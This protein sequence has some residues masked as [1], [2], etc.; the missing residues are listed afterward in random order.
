[1]SDDRRNNLVIRIGLIIT[2]HR[3]DTAR[4]GMRWLRPWAQ[5]NILPESHRLTLRHS[6]YHQALTV[7]CSPSCSLSST[8]TL[9]RTSTPPNEFMVMSPLTI[10]SSLC[11]KLESSFF[12]SDSY[13]P[14]KRPKMG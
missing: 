7:C 14:E 4:E 13:G 5:K 10:D 11:T 2:I 6:V 8:A 12:L 9:S 1:M 3:L